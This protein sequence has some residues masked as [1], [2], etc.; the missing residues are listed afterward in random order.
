MVRVFDDLPIYSIVNVQWL[1]KKC[2]TDLVP[3]D[4]YVPSTSA[5]MRYNSFTLIQR[6]IWAGECQA[7]DGQ[8]VVFLS[9]NLSHSLSPSRGN[10]TLLNSRCLF[11]RLQFDWNNLN[12]TKAKWLRGNNEKWDETTLTNEEKEG[13]FTHTHTLRTQRQW[14]REWEWRAAF[15]IVKF[16]DLKLI[17]L[18]VTIGEHNPITVA[19]TCALT[20]LPIQRLLWNDSFSLCIWIEKK[21]ENVGVA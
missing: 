17:C 13:E 6:I 5:Y 21:M 7:T 20:L 16:G 9:F 3:V 19:L 1:K 14:V 12:A 4:Y 8:D 15:R 18:T 11:Y 10:I 2:D